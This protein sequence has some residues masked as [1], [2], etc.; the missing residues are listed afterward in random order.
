METTTDRLRD[1]A[2]DELPFGMR[3]PG[4]GPARRRRG[5]VAKFGEAIHG[6]R[7]GM[8]GQSSFFVHLFFAVLAVAAAAVFDCTAFEWC[9]VVGCIG[10]VFTA[11]LFNTA[12][13]ILFRGLAPEA[14]DR[15]Y[16]CLHVAA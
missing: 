10:L 7:V 15:V 6:I 5:W 11:E 8:Q 13:E 4:D 1:A 9:L 12:I 14:R 3:A 2:R 16:P